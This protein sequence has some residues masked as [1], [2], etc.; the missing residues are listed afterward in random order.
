MKKYN[1]FSFLNTSIND[2]H[3]DL[4]SKYG[5]DCG[6]A[7]GYVAIP[8][9][10]PL[11]GKSYDEAYEAGITAHG[12]LTYSDSI[13]NVLSN[14]DLWGIDWLDGEVPED[15]WVFGFDTMHAGDTLDFW[16]CEK[17]IEETK[18]LKEQFENW[19]NE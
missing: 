17:C 6:Y 14:F 11:Y 3:R 15:Y 9:N 4:V 2:H 13:V 1:C 12:G 8:T 16:N 10:H 18:R 7:N 5:M 19:K